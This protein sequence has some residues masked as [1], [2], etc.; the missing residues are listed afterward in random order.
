MFNL[1]KKINA[2]NSFFALSI[3]ALGLLMAPNSAQAMSFVNHNS[4]LTDQEFNSLIDNGEFSELFVAEGRIGDC[5]RCWQKK[6]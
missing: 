4:D 2:R 6:N 3:T 5:K 1:T